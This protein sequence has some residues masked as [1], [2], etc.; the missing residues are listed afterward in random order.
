[1]STRRLTAQLALVVTALALA[2]GAAGCG[3]IGGGHTR[4]LT[5]HFDRTI[6]LY[7]N[8]DVRIL[9]VKIGKVTSL[10]P[11]GATVR[12]EMEYDT[13]YKIP[14]A[15]QAVVVAPSI[16]SDRYVQL[17]PAYTSGPELADGADLGTRTQIP[18]E[19]DDIFASIDKLDRALGPNGANK[20]GALQD[21]LNVGAK[22]LNGNGS[23][24]NSTV[25][26][27]STAVQTLSDQRSDLFGTVRN[28][29][30]FTTT[31]A[32][33]DDTVREFNS[34]LA[35]VASQLEGEKQDLA[36]AI[37]Q[38]SL[39]LGEVATFVRENSKSLTANV[40]DLADLTGVLVKQKAA[41]EEFLDTAPTALTNLQLAYNPASG[42]LDT[43]ANNLSNE[44]GSTLCNLG[45]GVLPQQLLNLCGSLV[46]GLSPATLK[47]LLSDPSKLTP[48][49]TQKLQ[50]LLNGSAAQKTQVTRAPTTGLTIPDLLGGK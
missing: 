27:L 28:L 38:L 5:A 13:K 29:A 43:R 17:T 6:G 16:V 50:D 33:S 47:Q 46:D 45:T 15:A 9:G 8:S 37:R 18:V 7:K 49:L 42:T 3:V 34:R 40:S 36:L 23:L 22:N 21:L 44:L 41:L 39:S 4:T 20:N 10:E 31:I 1:M 48:A 2:G 32:K 14:A 30:D 25:K 26:G 24:L 19:L 35:D 11:E 12:V